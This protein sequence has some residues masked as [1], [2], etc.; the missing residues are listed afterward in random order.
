MESMLDA[1]PKSTTFNWKYPLYVFSGVAVLAIGYFIYTSLHS[2]SIDKTDV[3]TPVELN[4]TVVAPAKNTTA[5]PAK[6]SAPA[7]TTIP[8]DTTTKRNVP[9]ST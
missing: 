4:N 2:K 3:S 1:A 9:T 7:T 5:A 8:I 6:I